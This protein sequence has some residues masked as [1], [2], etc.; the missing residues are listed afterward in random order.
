MY[1]KAE[2]S[3]EFI[4]HCKSQ[5]HPL[6][7]N[8]GQFCAGVKIRQRRPGRHVECAADVSKEGVCVTM[9]VSGSLSVTQWLQSIGGK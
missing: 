6:V 7:S 3:Y 4:V 5:G 9:E 2:S 1:G 8:I